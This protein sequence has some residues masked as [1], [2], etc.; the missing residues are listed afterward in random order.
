MILGDVEAIENAIETGNPTAV[1]KRA[2]RRLFVAMGRA[3]AHKGD[4]MNADAFYLPTHRGHRC[5]RS[6]T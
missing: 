1:A 2:E 5:G 6:G 3:V 4:A